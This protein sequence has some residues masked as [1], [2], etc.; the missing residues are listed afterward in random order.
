MP[1]REPR[2]GRIDGDVAFDDVWFEYNAGQP[3]LRGVSFKAPAG[4]T[5]ALVGS[6]GSG[7]STL[8]SLVMA[9]NRPTQGRVLIDG[10]DLGDAAAGRLPDAARVGAAGELPVRRH[11]RRQRRLRAARRHAATRSRGVPHR[12]LRRVHLAVPEGLRHGRR[13]AR[14]QA[15][16]RAAAARVDRPRDS[17]QPAHPDSRRGDVEPRQRE[18]ADDPGRP[19][20]AAI[21]PHHVRHRPSP[22]DD[23]QRGSDSGARRRERSSSAARTRS[24]WPPTV[25]TVSST[26]SST[27]SRPIGSSIPAKTSRPSRRNRASLPRVGTALWT[28]RRIRDATCRLGHDQ[29]APICIL[30][31]IAYGLR[32]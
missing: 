18:R 29:R 25:A 23:S 7:K 22:V 32:Q 17:G 6:S 9:F 2:A 5:T 24:C 14:H 8:I 11:D 12:A 21:R 1:T 28:K 26:T 30:L 31:C 20:A 13:R 3:V 19:A 15:V 10:R 4:T 27:S 16:G